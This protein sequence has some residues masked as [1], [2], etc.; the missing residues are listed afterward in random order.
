MTV[1]MPRDRS[2]NV[3]QVVGVKTAANVN[4]SGV[5]ASSSTLAESTSQVRLQT[6]GRCWVS[7]DGTAVA[8]G[9]NNSIPMSSD[10]TE[11]FRVRGGTTI[12]VIQDTA[13]GILNV[14]EME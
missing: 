5:A 12:S 8:D 13:T 4:F 1:R 10:Q 2:G 6:D 7:F 11:H 3:L 14:G 9:S